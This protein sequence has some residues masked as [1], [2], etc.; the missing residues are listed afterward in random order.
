MGIARSWIAVMRMVGAPKGRPAQARGS[1]AAAETMG[2]SLH[3][4]GLRDSVQS[5][6]RPLSRR[7]Q[8]TTRRRIRHG[9]RS[10][11]G[12][13]CA[14]RAC[15]PARRTASEPSQVRSS[16][17]P[18]LPSRL[19][20]PGRCVARGLS[21]VDRPVRQRRSTCAPSPPLPTCPSCRVRS[22]TRRQLSS[23]A[24]PRLPA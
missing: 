6:R 5:R 3:L 13:G 21:R 9:L 1:C 23:A 20:E 15:E 7:R 14:R 11:S 10:D 16:R 12:R 19:R 22:R 2:G 18:R 17:S 8:R 4:R 24:A